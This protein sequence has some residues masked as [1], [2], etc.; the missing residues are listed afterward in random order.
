MRRVLLLG[1]TVIAFGCSRPPAAVEPAGAATARDAGPGDVRAEL[2]RRDAELAAS[3]AQV[4]ELRRLLD[5]RA[6]PARDG[7]AAEPT[8]PLPPAGPNGLVVLARE[9]I[10]EGTVSSVAFAPDGKTVASA[11]T[12]GRVVI[13]DAADLKPVRAVEAVTGLGVQNCA[14]SVCFA[15]DGRYVAAGSEDRTVWVWRAEDGKLM[16]RVRGHRDAVEHVFFLP[17][18]RGGLSFDRQGVGLAWSI[19]GERRELVPDRRIRKAALTPDGELLAWSDGGRTVCGPPSQATPTADLGSFADALAVSRDGEAV[20]KGSS[21]YCVEVW[22]PHTG[23]R[24]WAGP[25][26]PA[27]VHSL[28]FRAD[29]K[30]LVSLATGTLSVWDV[31][32][33]DETHRFR[34]RPEDGACRMALGGDGRTL[35]VGNRQGMLTL[36]R[37]PE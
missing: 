15:P 20:A 12:L 27:R 31:R 23:T 11:D 2:A 28:A 34:V 25:P 10:H 3:R 32:T 22:D 21:T 35:A 36:V 24:R 18:G 6:R 26:L 8:A 4:E 33:G 16:K 37:L 14:Y 1:C 5:E 30:K 7:E 13:S 29:G 17:D 9:R 19:D